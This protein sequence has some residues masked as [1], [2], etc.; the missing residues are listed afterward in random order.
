[1]EF[2]RRNQEVILNMK[3]CKDDKRRNELENNLVKKVIR[4]A[5]MLRGVVQDDYKTDYKTDMYNVKWN[6]YVTEGGEIVDYLM[7]PSELLRYVPGTNQGD[8]S[9]RRGGKKARKLRKSRKA[10]KTRKM[11]KMRKSRRRARR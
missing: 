10:H 2:F 4:R 6:T 8:F 11:K 1:M 3:G 9:I 7:Y 5:D